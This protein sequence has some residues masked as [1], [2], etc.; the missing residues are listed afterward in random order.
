MY[1][2]SADQPKGKGCNVSQQKNAYYF[3]K[4][5]ML[6]VI[7][8]Q[9]GIKPAGKHEKCRNGKTSGYLDKMFVGIRNVDAYH[10]KGAKK[11][12]TVESGISLGCTGHGLHLTSVKYL[13]ANNR[14]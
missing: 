3:F 1:I 11:P 9:L 10:T 2:F 4:I 7:A 14:M 12:K 8:A 5:Y 6:S 13:A